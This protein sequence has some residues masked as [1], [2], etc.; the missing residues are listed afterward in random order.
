MKVKDFIYYIDNF[1]KVVILD[2]DYNYLFDN[3]VV[4]LY[5]E[6]LNAEVVFIRPYE[7][8]FSIRVNL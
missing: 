4:F 3:D 6:L 1:V 5:G 8:G 2:N 7:N